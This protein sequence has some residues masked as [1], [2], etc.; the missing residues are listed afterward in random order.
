MKLVRTDRSA[1][2]EWLWT[3]DHVVLVSVGLLILSGL[4]LGLA[5]SPPVA[6]RLHLDAFYFMQ[7]QV[8]FLVP[9]LVIL[10]GVSMVS[11]KTIK[12][13]G[14]ALF[15]L[16][17]SLIILTLVI[18]VEIKGATRWLYVGPFSLQP[19]EFLK[20]GFVIVLATLLASAKNARRGGELLIATAVFLLSAGL[21][22]LQ[23]DFGQT[24]LIVAVFG[25][26]LFLS[27]IPR[28][29]ILSGVGLSLVG[30]LAAYQ[31]VPHVRS[32]I[33]RFLD[34]ASGDTFQI[35]RALDAF[36]NGGF[37]GLGL[38]EGVVKRIL[39]DAHTDFVFAV[40]AEELG[41]IACMILLGLFGLIVLR[42]LSR[43]FDA[44]DSFVQLAVT[45]L[46]SVFGLQ[47]F[48]NMAVN[49]NML[50]AKGMTLPFVSYGGSS[51][52]ALSVTMGM[53]LALTRRG[54]EGPARNARGP[55]RVRSIVR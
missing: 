44:T 15:G 41:V 16:S 36:H 22:V 9:A 19:S 35:D 45:G 6:D 31:W 42:G 27:G 14:F 48:V 26:M 20:P 33:D 37:L 55:I 39:P 17:I 10:L 8:I 21:L 46:V 30:S 25:V 23:P 2:S 50:P 18:G 29:W 24:F 13:L 54:A 53:V 47:A 5:A 1:I 49:M 52:L 28:S 51:L 34:P 12:R 3:V 40:A 7:R 11:P 4:F 43:A 38:G 32:R